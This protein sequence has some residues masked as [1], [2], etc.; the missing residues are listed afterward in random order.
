M[1]KWN[2]III[3]KEKFRSCID[4]GKNERDWFALLLC[5]HVMNQ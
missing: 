4:C 3:H 5:A 1:D 2:K